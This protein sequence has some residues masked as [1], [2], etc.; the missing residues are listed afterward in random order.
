MTSRKLERVYCDFHKTV[1]EST[2][3]LRC[4]GTFDDLRRI[5]VSL[6]VGLRFTFWMDDGDGRGI[7]DDLLVDGVVDRLEDGTWVARVD[8]STWRH[9]SDERG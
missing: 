2:F 3:A 8:S 5:G 4:R 7:R 1:D 6:A 9:A